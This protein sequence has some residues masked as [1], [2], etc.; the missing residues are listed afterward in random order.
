MKKLKDYT[1]EEMYHSC[2]FIK[3]DVEM[4]CEDDVPI[5]CEK[6]TFG[7]ICCAPPHHGWDKYMEKEVDDVIGEVL[8]GPNPTDKGVSVY[9]NDN[10]I[11]IN[12]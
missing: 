12:L 7:G 4:S 8:E 5:I 2:L 11:Y 3:N 9:G 1:I 10:D 6:C